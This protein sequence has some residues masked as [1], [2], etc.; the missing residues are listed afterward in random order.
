MKGRRLLLNY[1][2]LSTFL[3]CA[4]I[5]FAQ[6]EIQV[7]DD[8]ELGLPGVTLYYDGLATLST[9]L[10][11]KAE[12]DFEKFKTLGLSFLGYEET[13]FT[14]SQIEKAKFVLVMKSADELIEEILIVGRT[15]ANSLDLPYQV[16]SI[17]SKDI[18]LSQAQTSADA[19]EKTGSVYVQKS[20]MGGG[21]PVLRGFEA[22]KILLVVD[23]VRMNNAIYRSGHLQNAITI[24]PAILNRAELIYG[25]GSLLYGSDAIGGVIHFRTKNPL[26]DTKKFG[27][28][29]YVR[30]ASANDERS[31]HVN[32]T[33][34]NQKN[35]SSLTSISL[36][37][38]G[39]LRAGSNRSSE[40][41]DFGKLF[42]Y[43]VRENDE[44]VI[45]QNDDPNVQVGTSY[46]Q[47]DILEK[48]IYQ[49]NEKIRAG[50][51]IQFSNSSDIPRYD[52]L[53]E[54]RNGSLRYAEWSYG[55]QK[56]FLISPHI[57]IQGEGKLF[58][59]MMI[60]SSY[61]KINESR[62]VRNFNSNLLTEQFEDLNVYGVNAD[63][64]RTFPNN[65]L[66]EY[67]ASLY[68]NELMSTKNA[69]D[70][71]TNEEDPSFLTRYP[72]GGSSM[73]QT[74]IYAHHR[75]DLIKDI[76]FWNVGARWSLQSTK[77]SYLSSDSVL[78]PDFYYDGIENNNNSF[79]WMSGLNYRKDNWQIKFLAG[80]AYRAPNVDDLA[81]IRVNANEIT[82]PNPELEP[83]KTNN[84][85]INFSYNSKKLKF[86]ATAFYSSI[87][88]IVVRRNFI[89]P[90]GSDV[91]ISNLDT[92]NVTAN[93]NA[94]KG[95]VRGLSGQFEYD[96]TESF[97]LAASINYT[98][99]ISLDEENIESPLDHIPPL[100]GRVQ[101]K[102]SKGNWEN[103][104]IMRYNGFKDIE[105]YG[106]SADNP[107]YALPE[108][109]PSWQTLNLYTSYIHKNTWTLRLS[110]ENI[111]D[112][113][114]RTF[115]SGLSAPGR[116]LI[117]SV[118]YNW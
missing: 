94:V 20:Q 79:V 105:D 54:Y 12:I 5:C 35:L 32:F 25:P 15:N 106:G 100:Y 96:L 84:V 74:G 18:R 37:S 116:N 3:L 108:G 27:G 75:M 80:S 81:K 2:R 98:L 82:V 85:E 86:G 63:F 11:G 9:D 72:S 69:Q 115:A 99:G 10:N 47:I 45:V 28:E 90:D 56:R 107:E 51:N 46:K 89:L 40:Y 66:I 21:S 48:I 62:R 64:R 92:L 112:L 113:H 76:L 95:K 60:N 111:F 87:D 77:F 118:N 102:Y 44:D 30:Y 117:F 52:F 39:D 57:E 6:Q 83:E 13:Y 61:Q 22:N 49:A 24:D 7:I 50:L 41:P 58:D 17:D 71:I 97:S 42:E 53:S 29:S 110:L 43:V 16:E 91:F 19:I 8:D 31:A 23:G 68:Y 114:Y 34:S 59:V 4:N 103:S 1:L 101:L 65:S 55:P 88:D 36:S 26:I 14:K 33:L 70:I 38:F 67:G 73:L 104:L 109:T 93:V 78:W